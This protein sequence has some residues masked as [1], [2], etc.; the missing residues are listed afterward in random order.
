MVPAAGFEPATFRLQ[1][2]CTTT[3]LS[4][5]FRH[6]LAIGENRQASI[7]NFTLPC[8]ASVYKTAAL[9]LCYAGIVW[10]VVSILSGPGSSFSFRARREAGNCPLLVLRL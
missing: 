5:H 2:D 10:D 8:H 9:P 4:R 6:F 1:S 7:E 3:V